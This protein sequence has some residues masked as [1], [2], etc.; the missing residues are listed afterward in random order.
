MRAQ[1]CLVLHC[2][3]F[4]RTLFTHLVD[5]I[6]MD[7][8]QPRLEPLHVY[9]ERIL[10]SSLPHRLLWRSGL[11]HVGVDR[12]LRME[13]L[14]LYLIHGHDEDLGSLPYAYNFFL[15]CL[16][17][18]ASVWLPSSSRNHF[19]STAESTFLCLYLE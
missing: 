1:R 13:T 15:I 17:P 5:S 14:A 3:L 9:R 16:C 11:Y 7:C 19:V 6:T 12:A 18:Y 10:P 2:G 4:I 8:S